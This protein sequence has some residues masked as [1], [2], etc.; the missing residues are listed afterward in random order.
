MQNLQGN[1]RTEGSMTPSMQVGL[2]EGI[3][4]LKKYRSKKL[5]P[6]IPGLE[7]ERHTYILET[8]P[9][10]GFPYTLGLAA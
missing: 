5:S 1:V 3:D 7:M 10:K 6:V 2:L 4:T 9:L 8:V